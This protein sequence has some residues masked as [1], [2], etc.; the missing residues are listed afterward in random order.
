MLYEVITPRL[1]DDALKSLE[2][3]DTPTVMM[4]S[5][6]GSKLPFVDVDNT[7]AAEKATSYLVGLGHRD[8]ACISNAP[9]EYTAAP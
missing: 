6:A 4:G 5:I 2:N 3:V 7:K 9:P 8:I 1:N